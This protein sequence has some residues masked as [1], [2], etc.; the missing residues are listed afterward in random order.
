MRDPD[1]CSYDQVDS[2]VIIDI[3]MALLKNNKTIR[4]GVT[5]ELESDRRETLEFVDKRCLRGMLPEYSD[6]PRL[7]NR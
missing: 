6:S 7:H 3:G 4:F 1:L 2:E 5:Q